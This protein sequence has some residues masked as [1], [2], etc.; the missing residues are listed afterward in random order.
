MDTKEITFLFQGVVD[1]SF[2]RDSFAAVRRIFPRSRIVLSSWIGTDVTGLDFDELALCE[3]P[4]FFYYSDQPGEKANNVNRQ[5]VGTRAGLEKVTTPYCFRLRTDFRLNGNGFLDF[6][7]AFP[8]SDDDYAL[9][10]HKLLACSYFSR[11]PSSRLRFPFHPSDL[12][13]FGRTDDIRK[14][15]DVPLM[16]EEEASWDTGDRRYNRYTPEQHIFVNA[17]RRDGRAVP[18]ACYNDGNEAA[19]LATERYFASNFVLLS[20]DQ[21]NLQPSKPTFFMK[22]HPNSF[23]TCYTHNEWIGLYKKHVDPN[24]VVPEHDD[25]REKIDH[26][27]GPYKACRLLGNMMSLPFKSKVKRRAIRTGVLEFF[28]MPR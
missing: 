25:E 6:F 24:A 14:L 28:L 26:Y 23:R 27:Y 16:T 5:I 22:V 7:D 2:V 11:N 19:V 18:C 21:F 8:D 4:G 12:A 17:L 1:K 15:F 10:S 20:F 3:D 9:F 13:F